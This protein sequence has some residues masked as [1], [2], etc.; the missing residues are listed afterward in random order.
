[1][2]EVMYGMMGTFRC[3]IDFW[4]SFITMK[5]NVTPQ[6]CNAT[7]C[8]CLLKAVINIYLLSC[9]TYQTEFWPSRMFLSKDKA[10]K[11]W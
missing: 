2:P 7:R 6:G 8:S 1:M 10:S 5:T 3:F 11:S 9:N 4:R